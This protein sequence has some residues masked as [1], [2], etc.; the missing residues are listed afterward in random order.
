M[1][2]N[3]QVSTNDNSENVSILIVDDNSIDRFMI[4]TVCSGLNVEADMAS[5]GAEALEK[6]KKKRHRLVIT[7]YV[8][9]PMSGLELSSKLREIDPQVEIMLVSGAP[10]A[11][12][13]AYVQSNDLAPVITKP[14]SPRALINTAL[15]SLDRKRGRREVLGEVALSNRMDACLPLIGSSDFCRKLRTDV[16]KLLQTEDSIFI[17]GPLGCGKAEV[18]NLLHKE[19]AHG[20][21]ICL[22]CFCSTESA[23]ELSKSLIT[24]DGIPGEIIRTAEAG[25][26]ILHNIESLPMPLQKALSNNF[27]ALIAKVQLLVLSNRSLDDLLDAEQIDEGLYFKLSLKMLE[28]PALSERTEDLPE[29]VQYIA[30]SPEKY[31][32]KDGNIDVENFMQ[33]ESYTKGPSEDKSLISVMREYGEA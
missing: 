23:E 19:G 32:L 25:T 22:E 1:S 16:T 33:S 15:L 8:M 14:I 11:E 9:E 2:E 7:D 6:F 29:M 24:E 10:T 30:N 12:V 13:L 3:T 26:L 4:T 5:T 21:S 20:N 28:L 18:A 31:G 17:S 27:D